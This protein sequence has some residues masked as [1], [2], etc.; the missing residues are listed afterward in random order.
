MPPS[1]RLSSSARALLSSAASPVKSQNTHRIG[2]GARD[3]TRT[4]YG[5][6]GGEELL[7]VPAQINIISTSVMHSRCRRW[8]MGC[9]RASVGITTG[10]P[11]IAADLVQRPGRQNK[12]HSRLSRPILAPVK[13]FATL[14]GQA[15]EVVLRWFILVVALLLDPA[16]V[17]LLL[18]ATRQPSYGPSR[19][20]A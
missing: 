2:T 12:R 5:R 15:D 17:L 4:P 14:L 6:G 7:F 3:K 18:A 9:R 11:Q 8:V 20:I 13:Y 10:V 16:A 1:R 19:R